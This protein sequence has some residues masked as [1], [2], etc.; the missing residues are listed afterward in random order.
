MRVGAAIFNQN[1][2]DWDRY[3]AEE[4]GTAVPKRA[5]RADR[6]VFTEELNLARTARLGTAVPRSSAS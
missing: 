1:Y 3:E 2:N 5:V 6:E 4:R